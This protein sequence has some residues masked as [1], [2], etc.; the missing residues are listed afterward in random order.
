MAL[1]SG[2]ACAFAIMAPSAQR[3]G[4]RS[5]LACP[6]DA[7]PAAHPGFQT[8]NLR[9]GGAGKTARTAL[10]CPTVLAGRA[11]A[12]MLIALAIL[13]ILPTAAQAQVWSATLTV[14]AI[15]TDF[16]CEA[17]SGA[18]GCETV[19][20]EDDFT[21]DGTTYTIASLLL[22]ST[23]T[24]EIKF[25]SV[26]S[27]NA[28]YLTLGVVADTFPFQGADEDSDLATGSTRAWDNSGLSWANGDSVALSLTEATNA[29]PSFTSLPTFGPDENQMA[30]GTVAASDS[31]APD[32]V[33]GYAFAG[34][35]DDALFSITSP[36]GVLTFQTAPNYESP[37]DTL[38]T[39]PANAAGN[40]EYVLK[41][42][43]T[44]GTG[45]RELTA[46][47]TI[48]V[49]VANVAED[50]TGLPTISGTA[51]VG[52]TLTASTSDIRDPDGLDNVSYAYQWIR[53][54]SGT[55]S[56]ITGA[57][58]NTYVLQAADQGKTIKVTVTF[59]D[60]GGNTE[61][62]ASAA[63]AGV[64]ALPR[65]PVAPPARVRV[66]A[67]Y[68]QMLVEWSAARGATEYVVEWK[69]QSAPG[70]WSRR[71]TDQTSYTISGLTNGTM[72]AVRVRAANTDGV[73]D[74]SPAV[75]GTPTAP[76]RAPTEVQATAGDRHLRV[77]WSAVPD[78]T[79]YEL[80]WRTESEGYGSSRQRT[81]ETPYAVIGHLTNGTPYTVRVR[82][83]NAGGESDWSPKV[84]GTPE[85]DAGPE[86]VPALP[87]A[88]MA[89]LGLLLLGM[90]RRTLRSRNEG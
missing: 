21:Y 35:A 64:T 37:L 4:L 56:D 74:W 50:P 67:G 10:A 55:D 28:L 11:A 23:A 36:G 51:Q 58:E 73:S 13:L 32:S 42:T 85:S 75:T 61:I 52:Q 25:T 34:G 81:I 27:V 83:L 78:A 82:A 53:V 24:L 3:P 71:Q 33:T 20:T 18:N 87:M 29:S 70:G 8:A 39:D 1:N 44:S 76:P 89:G 9:S 7:A 79:R 48:T 80:Q 2:D 88:G 38:S 30:V 16:G 54:D 62:L 47:Q 40:N 15:S 17:G 77:D 59:D 72:Y 41:V 46:E 84:T 63:T 43:A 12:G 6:P 22:D 49:T 14:K 86:P 90:A 68:G 57:T 5:R 60:D 31:D 65:P 45:A 69:A 19:L 66:T 26:L